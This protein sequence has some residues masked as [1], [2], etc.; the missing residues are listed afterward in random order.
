MIHYLDNSATTEPS[1]IAKKAAL[2][3]LEA[4]GNPSS[5]YSLG[6]ASRRLLEAS[7]EKVAAALGIRRLNGAAIVFTASGTEANCLSILGFHAAKN[8]KKGDSYPTVLVGDG[9]HPSVAGAMERLRE[10]G[11]DVVTVPT[12]GGELDFDVIGKTCLEKNVVYAAFMLVNNETGALYDV[13]RAAGVVHAAN[14]NAVVHCDAVQGF[15]KTKCSPAHLGVDTL[16]VSAHKIHAP[17]GAAALYISAELVKRREIAPVLP[18]GGQE[19]GLRSGTENLVC[20]SA[21]AAAAED[22]AANF[23]ERR[24]AVASLRAYL[25]EKLS[26]IPEIKI[27]NPASALDDIVNITLPRIKSETMLSFLSAREIYVS[28]GSACSASSGRLSAALTAFG[29]E[30]DEIDSSLRVSISYTNTTDDIDA[31][32]AALRDGIASLARY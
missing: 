25:G 20:I 29:C 21:F 15:M 12:V 11:Y 9:E 2:E 4:Y 7:R 22:E 1:P 26:E 18:G 27:K 13:K 16:T 28:A 10:V 8:R 31:L 5:V 24:A 14:R 6:V 32:C 23:T 19:G 3:A 17:R 30:K